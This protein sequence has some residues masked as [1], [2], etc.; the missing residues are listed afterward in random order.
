[1]I[2]F[3]VKAKVLGGNRSWLKGLLPRL[4]SVYISKQ[5]GCITEA[6]EAPEPLKVG[7]S[8]LSSQTAFEALSEAANRAAFSGRD[9][10][11]LLAWGQKSKSSTI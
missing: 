3:T 9:T 1:M 4:K 5:T 2:I 8:P 11:H 6:I 7:T 10:A